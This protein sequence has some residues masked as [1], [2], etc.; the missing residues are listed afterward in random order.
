MEQVQR[1]TFTEK[2]GTKARQ[3]G[4]KDFLPSF[5][6]P[7]ENPMIRKSILILTLA[8]S[9]LPQI[10]RADAINFSFFQNATNNLFQNRYARPDQVSSLNFSFD[11][12]FRSI[13][14]FSQGGYSYLF[15]NPGLSYFS[16]Q[17]GLDYLHALSEK[18]ALYFSLTGA[19][20]LF[21]DEFADFNHSSIHFQAAYKS[22]IRET[23]ILKSSYNLEYRN[24]G[25]S[26]YDFISQSLIFSLDKYFQTRTTV[27]GEIDWGY[28]YFLH[29]YLSS[30]SDRS[31]AA[32]FSQ[33][34]GMGFRGG[35]GAGGVFMSM[36]GNRGAGIQNVSLSALLAQGLGDKAGLR[37]SLIR[38][39][40]LSGENPF[41]FIEEYYMVEN[42]SYDNYSWEGY[43]ANV[44]M[45]IEM[46]WMSE[47]KM[48]YTVSRKTFP[49][50]DGL[51][52]EG[53]S[54]GITR[55]DRRSQWDVRLEKNFSSFSLFLNYSSV[56]NRSNDPLFGWK[57]SFISGGI[58]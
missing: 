31:A 22:Y 38:Q 19:G 48:G 7:K 36:A 41:V 14:L 52:L 40:N 20:S 11:K 4:G 56:S 30:S 27:K 6:P 25:Y 47:L 10:L 33:G 18:K 29:P 32:S 51:D 8:I 34:Q 54:L 1:A 21:R 5:S 23:S 2:D 44:L 53:N 43:G 9:A 26:L 24:Y 57:G 15:K 55:E 37:I 13:S 16:F 58:G 42:P 17:A 49:G 28:K 39:W 12:T 3:P 50:I 35:R 45:T 46:P